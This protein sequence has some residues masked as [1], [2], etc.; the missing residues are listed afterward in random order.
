MGRSG[1]WDNVGYVLALWPGSTPVLPTQLSVGFQILAAEQDLGVCYQDG[2]PGEEE[3]AAPGQRVCP[4]PATEPGPRLGSVG[5]HPWA[6]GHDRGLQRR[7]LGILVQVRPGLLGLRGYD[8]GNA[9]PHYSPNQCPG[10]WGPGLGLA[11]NNHLKARV[12]PVCL[13]VSLGAEC[14]TVPTGQYNLGF[15]LG[16]IAALG[17]WVSRIPPLSRIV[18]LGL[19]LWGHP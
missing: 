18:S 10:G 13:G 4:G 8:V 17:S 11:G 5:H 2:A 6:S 12:G 14:I 9:G 7:L 1:L 19:G 16:G 15:L 3:A